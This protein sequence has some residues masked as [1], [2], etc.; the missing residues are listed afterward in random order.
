MLKQ[1]EIYQGYKDN[2]YEMIAEK[3]EY[4]FEDLLIKGN[5]GK[6]EKHHVLNQTNVLLGA[7]SVA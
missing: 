4:Y 1:L 6:Q 7:I 5:P 3:L 2:T